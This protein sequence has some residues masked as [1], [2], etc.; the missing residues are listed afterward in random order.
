MGL[1]NRGYPQ[2]ELLL[3]CGVAAKGANIRPLLD[4]GYEGL[5]LAEQIRR[6]RITSIARFMAQWHELPGQ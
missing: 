1:E 5:K 6:L 2:A 3:A 4:D